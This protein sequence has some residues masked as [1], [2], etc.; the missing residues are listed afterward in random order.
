MKGYKYIAQERM[1]GFMNKFQEIM[2]EYVNE[3]SRKAW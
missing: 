2:E 3:L 1:N